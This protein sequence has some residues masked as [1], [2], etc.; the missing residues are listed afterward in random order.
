MEAEERIM[1]NS[2]GLIR[3][4][5]RVVLEIAMLE[6]HSLHFRGRSFHSE[7][8]WEGQVHTRAK[9]GGSSSAG[10]DLG[11]LVDLNLDRVQL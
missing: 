10:Q 1:S 6:G 3:F 8:C 11:V 7:E 5:H 4:I 9:L 2:V